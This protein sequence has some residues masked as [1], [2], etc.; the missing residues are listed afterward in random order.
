MSE[1]PMSTDLVYQ[2]LLHAIDT[3]SGIGFHNA[4]Q[5]HPAY[6]A[7]AEDGTRD[8]NG[9][10]DSPEAN[11]VYKMLPWLSERHGTP[12]NQIRNWREFC[13]RAYKASRR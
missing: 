1:A 2:A 7:G 3:N 9:W 8:L 6:Q 11:G 12:G 13:Q 4:D 10:G 5:G